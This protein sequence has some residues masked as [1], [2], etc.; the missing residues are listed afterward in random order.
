VKFWTKLT[1]SIAIAFSPCAQ[2]DVSNTPAVGAVYN[3]TKIIKEQIVSGMNIVAR[4][5]R[6]ASLFMVGS[7]TLDA[8]ILT[9]PLDSAIK[10]RVIARL[11]NPAYSIQ[12]GH[13]LYLFYDRY[14]GL[15]ETD[16]FR[17]HL[18]D[19][20][21]TSELLRYQHSLFDPVTHSSD[22]TK[23][24]TV[25]ND[26]LVINAELIAAAVTIYDVLFNNDEWVLGKR[27]PESYQYLTRSPEDLAIISKVQNI[28][29]GVVTQ[30][31]Q[32]LPEGEMKTA[33]D[34]IIEDSKPINTT[35]VNNRAQALSIT[36]IDFVR[37]NVL[38]A[39]RQFSHAQLRVEAFNDWM[40]KTFRSDPDDLIQ[41]LHAQI[42]KRYAVQ[43]TVDGLQQGL[44]RALASDEAS[45]F[46][47]EVYRRSES[48]ITY[49]PKT[50]NVVVPAFPAT[51]APVLM[52]GRLRTLMVG[53]VA[54]PN[55]VMLFW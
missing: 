15:E 6:D 16:V 50:E 26:G 33:L 36:L 4:T 31:S 8:Y 44:L 28:I 54:I 17:Q 37:L 53:V 45:P 1:I 24:I 41:F 19:V 12:L 46:I 43:I 7:M 40:L 9:L 39:Y 18:L 32:S 29:I 5:G 2:A 38:K 48:R 55:R 49:K 13:F 22:E 23:T 11:T 20:Y 25:E 10:A 3:S 52:T 42:N 35:K 30:Y 47:P 27:L 51:T 21:P 34:G 14:T